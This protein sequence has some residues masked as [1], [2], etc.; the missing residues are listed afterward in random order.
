[1]VGKLIKIGVLV[2]LAGASFGISFVISGSMAPTATEQSAQDAALA[3]PDRLDLEKGLLDGLASMQTDGLNPAEKQLDELIRDVRAR[4]QQLDRRERSL[5]E[6]EKRLAMATEHLKK[7]SENLEKLRVELLSAITPLKTAKEDLLKLR[8]IIKD[9]EVEN[10]KSAAKMYT[11]MDPANAAKV[12]LAMYN[13]KQADQ[14]A[15]IIHFMPEKSWAAIMDE[16]KESGRA[17]E[18]IDR[19]LQVIKND[20]KT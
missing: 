15:K 10:L 12:I 9:Q 19:Q 20:G 7:Q 5:N 18:I 11:K 13:S 14:A 17:A 16:I 8:T 2:L 6:R 4:L 1:M 3:D